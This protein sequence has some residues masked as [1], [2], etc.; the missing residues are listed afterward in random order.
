MTSQKINCEQAKQIDLVSYLETLNLKPSKING[1][2]YW[3]YSPFHKENTPSF[4]INRKLNAW[5]DHSIGKGGK[6][7][8]FGIAYHNCTVAEFLGKLSN[9]VQYFSFQQPKNLKDEQEQSSMNSIEHDRKELDVFE[10]NKMETGR[11]ER[12]QTKMKVLAIK[13]LQN[14]KLK[15]YF[16]T[17]GIS[18]QNAH[19][20]CKEVMVEINQRLFPLIGFKN[21]SGGYELRGLPD[22]KSTVPPKDYSFFN[23]E[24]KA[25]AVVEGMFDFLSLL[26]KQSSF[27]PERT[28]FL[29]LNSLSFFEKAFPLMEEHEHVYLLLDNDAAGKNC[30]AAALKRSLKFTDLSHKYQNGKDLN[31]WLVKEKN[32]QQQVQQKQIQEK[33]REVQQ[34]HRRGL[35]R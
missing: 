9:H 27:L 14:E 30:A 12:E 23:K 15:N 21:N 18:S 33:N 31:D 35:R 7:V 8:D 5:Y 3:Y 25:L 34:V 28:N 22:F 10:Q 2:D 6:L 11:D 17:R 1:N 13:D 16:Q 24:N 4:K 20:Y 26:E 19:N 29:V 32:H